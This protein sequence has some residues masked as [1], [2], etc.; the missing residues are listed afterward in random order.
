MLNIL[1][2]SLLE[3]DYLTYIYNSQSLING[4]ANPFKRQKIP[5][6]LVLKRYHEK[7]YFRLWASLLKK[8]QVAKYLEPS[9][10]STSRPLSTL[11]QARQPLKLPSTY[12]K[13]SK[14]LQNKHQA[15]IPNNAYFQA[16]QTFQ[17][18]Y[19]LQYSVKMLLRFGIHSN[20]QKFERHVNL[21]P[22]NWFFK[23]TLH[24]EY[25]LYFFLDLDADSDF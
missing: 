6:C 1:P 22:A 20:S 18:W 4:S 9:A 21:R 15:L 5:L 10:S 13:T 16:M 11:K 19:V 24:F 23:K 17:P 12:I 3:V 7:R 2:T 8:K 14:P 25:Y